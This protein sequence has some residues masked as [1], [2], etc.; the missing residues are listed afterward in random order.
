MEQTATTIQGRLGDENEHVRLAALAE[1]M[2]PEAEPE[3][4][5]E[6]V[7]ASL[8]HSNEAVRQLAAVVL[9]QVAAQGESGKHAVPALARALDE[10]QPKSVR[11]LAASGLSRAGPDAAPAIEPLCRA[12]TSPDKTLRASASLALGKIG[13]PAVPW[14]RRLLRLP[15][16][17]T[18]CAAADALA[19]VGRPAKDAVE[20]LRSLRA[21]PDP[22]IQQACDSALEKVDGEPAEI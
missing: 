11:V 17:A 4:V 9:G 14:L 2:M 21:G 10:A 20:D 5:V 15:E 1:L 22:Q 3:Q 18:V 13:A 7:A 19:L 8:D 6:S 12:M 16:S